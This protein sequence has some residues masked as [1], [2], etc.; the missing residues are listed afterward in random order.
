MGTGVFRTGSR[1]KGEGAS[2]V[3]FYLPKY[4]LG[5]FEWLLGFPRACLIWL[6]VDAYIFVSHTPHWRLTL[7]SYA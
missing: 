3:L 2:L 7:A 6:S 4:L 5:L 1:G